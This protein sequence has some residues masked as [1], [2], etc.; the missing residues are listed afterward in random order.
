M[1]GEKSGVRLAVISQA[2]EYSVVMHSTA[3]Y[4]YN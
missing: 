3:K 1:T 2:L 4:D